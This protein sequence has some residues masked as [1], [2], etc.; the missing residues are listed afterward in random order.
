VGS[1]GSDYLDFIGDIREPAVLDGLLEKARAQVRD[2]CGFLFYHLPNDSMTAQLLQ[3]S[4]GRLGYDCVEEETLPAPYFVI[5]SQDPPEQANRTSLRR[6]ENFFRRSDNFEVEHLSVPERIT[7]LLSAFMRQHME[8][9]AAMPHPSLFTDPR[10]CRFYR[11]ITEAAGASGFVR[12]TRI[13]WGSRPVAHHFGFHYG[14][15]Y[16]WYKPAFDIHLAKRSPGEVLLRHLL[17]AA[18]AEKAAKFDF[19]M[20]DE[21]FKHRFADRVRHMSNLELYPKGGKR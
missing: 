1:G 6:H 8:R 3:H 14:G 9:W 21:P 2:F 10:Q 16:L 5:C 17:I 4:A 13:L 15:S 18:A 11:R 19:G 20:G 7:P 12:F